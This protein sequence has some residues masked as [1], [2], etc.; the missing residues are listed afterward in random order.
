M[1]TDRRTRDEGGYTLLDVLLY[2]IIAITLVIIIAAFIFMNQAVE[3]EQATISSEELNG[4][5]VQ[6][7]EPTQHTDVATTPAE[8]T[9]VELPWEGLLLGGLAIVGF[10]VLLGIG[11]GIGLVAYRSYSSIQEKRRQ[12]E[13]L[14]NKLA[15]TKVLHKRLL[16]R[17]SV[18]ELDLEMS[19]RYPLVTDLSNPLT[20][21][22][23]YSLRDADLARPQQ[24]TNAEV[25]EYSKKVSKFERDL[26]ILIAEAKRSAWNKFGVAER[27]KLDTAL[28]LLKLAKDEGAS[29]HERQIA[30]KRVISELEGIIVL[31]EAPL[32]MLEQSVMKQIETGTLVR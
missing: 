31:P 13:N 19:I 18:Y 20:S 17:W 28:N 27:K 2:T 8:S 22:M 12:Q 6:T 25:A 7:E 3:P 32:A 11:Y 4:K 24:A 30:Y 5:N 26:N 1:L 16:D 29:P 9:S 15:E 14:R 23:L 21:T 10:A